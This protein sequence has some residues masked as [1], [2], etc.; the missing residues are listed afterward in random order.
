MNF[1]TY[2]END[3]NRLSASQELGFHF[4]RL[5]NPKSSTV[6]FFYLFVFFFSSYFCVILT[7]IYWRFV[8]RGY[9]RKGR[10]SWG[11]FGVVRTCWASI[12]QDSINLFCFFF[13]F[14]VFLPIDVRFYHHV[15]VF[16]LREPK[17]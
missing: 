11:I 1:Y 7:L 5:L 2:S 3:A 4:I 9:P 17:P 16:E 15:I 14:L 13:L 6:A 8:M 10:E 12:K